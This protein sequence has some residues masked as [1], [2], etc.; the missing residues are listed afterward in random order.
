MQA[1]VAVGRAASRGHIAGARDPL[2]LP[3]EQRR[4][5]VARTD[6]DWF[7]GSLQG[8]PNIRSQLLNLFH[9]HSRPLPDRSVSKHQSK[10]K[11]HSDCCLFKYSLLFYNPFL[12]IPWQVLPGRERRWKGRSAKLTPS[13]PERKLCLI[14][15]ESATGQ[16]ELSYNLELVSLPDTKWST[17]T[18]RAPTARESTLTCSFSEQVGSDL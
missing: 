10:S 1:D 5:K 14:D 7:G 3:N 11:I 2:L 12:S 13:F 4:K 15:Q 9:L 6:F 17:R 16:R 18:Y 8:K